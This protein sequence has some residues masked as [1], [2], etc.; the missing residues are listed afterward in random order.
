MLHAGQVVT[1]TML[2]EDIWNF[3]APVQTN[4]VDVHVSN[5]RRKIEADGET[6]L[7]ANVPGVGFKLAADAT[8]LND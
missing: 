7:I 2:L 1:R 4:V 8:T 6:R 3:R 5:L